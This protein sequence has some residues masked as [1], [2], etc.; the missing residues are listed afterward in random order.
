MS[1]EIG[2]LKE[3]HIA[4]NSS[5]GRKEGSETVKGGEKRTRKGTGVVDFHGMVSGKHLPS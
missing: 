1:N 4:K 2:S 3:S 5:G